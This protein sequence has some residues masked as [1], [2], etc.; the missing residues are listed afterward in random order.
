LEFRYF[1][2]LVET[3]SVERQTI[4]NNTKKRSSECKANSQI[5]LTSLRNKRDRSYSHGARSEENRSPKRHNKMSSSLI[6][7]VGTLILCHAAYS[8]LHYRELL[9]DLEDAGYEGNSG[10]IPP[11]DVWMEVTVGFIAILG[12]ELTRSG[13]SLRPVSTRGKILQGKKMTP[14]AAPAFRSRDFDIYTTRAKVL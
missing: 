11:A 2:K 14:L 5:I 10:M 13:S 3:G 8:C 4:S 9:R 7:T 6:L 12:A 1:G